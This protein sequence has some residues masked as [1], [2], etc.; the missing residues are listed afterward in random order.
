MQ[1]LEYDFKKEKRK[2]IPLL[3][4]FISRCKSCG[5]CLQN[6]VFH[7]YSVKDS[8]KIMK[9]IKEFLLSKK[10]DKKISKATKKYIWTCGI[11]E[12]C[13]NMCPLEEKIPRS[14]WIILLRG[15]L[16]FKNEAPFIIRLIRKILFRDLNHPIFK[17]LWP[18]LGKLVPDWFNNKDPI[19]V[20]ERKS[21]DIARK[22]PKKSA[23]ICFFGGCG[24]TW[25]APDAVYGMMTILEEAGADFITIG[26]EEFCCGAVYAISGFIDLWLEHSY[27]VMQ[28]YMNLKPRPKILLL[29]CPGCYT[30]LKLDLTKYGL[31]LPYSYL[32]IMPTPIKMMHVIEYTL[33]LIREGK[34]ELKNEV[35]LTL[36]YNDNCS[37]GRRM[38]MT[39]R[40]IYNEPRELL[41]SIP[42]IK[43]VESEYSK[44]NAYCCG[45]MATKLHGMGT[46]LK[47]FIRK[48][49]AYMIQREIYENM[50]NKG[51]D[52]LVTPCMGCALA[53]EDSA[54]VWS[55][56]L[57][58][59]I[60]IY[61]INEL[62]NRS[63]G[64]PVPRRQLF[65][66]DMIGLSFPY[67]KGPIIKLIPRIIRTQ[68]FRDI[69]K[70]IREIFTYIRKK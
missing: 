45:I 29:H 58:R 55:S 41:E 19:L 14:L 63:L 44:E 28:K 62:V 16:V 39:G 69:Y 70:L 2:I 56:K 5:L 48:D 64:I 42:G 11:C 20:K 7:N 25:A 47:G 32:Q 10:L 21:I 33:Q 65:F 46:N 31:I 23:E 18:I 12:H 60:N 37:I 59:K 9:E 49:K 26:S 6:C 34:I 24:H 43:L 17:Y 8:K 51:S 15:I 22:V 50:L 38:A 35:S 3:R 61:E 66:N 40:P 68:A 54:R 30:I 27:N 67:I 4:K 36:T 1:E 57:G 13:N 52:S 53:F